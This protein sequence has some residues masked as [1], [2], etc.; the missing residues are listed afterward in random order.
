[1]V[2]N[3]TISTSRPAHTETAII[4]GGIAG[5]AT[6]FY[7][8]EYSPASAGFTLIECSPHLGG[9]ISSTQQDG[10]LIEGGPDSFLTQ[11]SAILA[12]CT[13]LGLDKQLVASNP[14]AANTFIWSR[15]QLHPIPHGMMLMAPTM[16]LPILRTRL[17]SWRGKL[18][19]ACEPLLPRGLSDSDESL[20]S[21]VRRRLGAETLRNIAG[22]LMAGIHAADPEKLSLRSTFPIFPEMEQKHGSLLRAMLKRRRQ[23]SPNSQPRP[24]FMSLKGGLQQLAGALVAH[25]PSSSLR[26]NCCVL[27]V[28]A[29]G[30]HYKLTLSNGSLLL[31]R[32]VVFAT[33][34]YVTADLIQI[35][36]P[37][38]ASKL[39][40]IR[41]VS[42]A[43]VSLGFK[44]SDIAHPLNG[45]GFL[46]PQHEGRRITAC[47]WS[48]Q[49][50]PYRAPDDHALLRVFIGG[51]L[52]ED[53][54]ELDEAA[55][56]QIAREE[57][58]IIMGIHAE[59]TI[60][61]AYRWR[62]GNP[63]YELGHAQ[64][65]AGIEH[66]VAP[67]P[68][69]HLVGAAYHGAGIPDCIQS[70][71]RAARA[72]VAETSNAGSASAPEPDRVPIEA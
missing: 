51:A 39:R 50:F 65:I 46:V 53:L 63:Q 21:F 23:A 54:A 66:A 40:E 69:L 33:P 9:K 52:A 6:A 56:I 44:R 11:K 17:I 31:A 1:M 14:A 57:L 28:T 35:I 61:R 10:F 71:L 38:L 60:A 19:M 48:S 22:P 36:D 32:N 12:L 4:G 37:A 58:K 3:H 7:L 27:S 29:H 13:R 47:S 25:L 15:G 49:K 59:P 5:L 16:L 42:T 24:M 55:L 43:T 45:S 67:L 68:G 2:S 8:R 34:A 70:G 30:D 41:Y 18:R 64:R 20:A 62:K 72:I 26:A